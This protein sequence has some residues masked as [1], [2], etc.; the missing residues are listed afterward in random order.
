MLSFLTAVFATLSSVF[1]SRSAFQLEN[2]ALR[3]QIGVL[4]RVGRKR[5]KLMPRDRLLWVWLSRIWSGWRSALAIVRP[6]TFIAC[7]RKGFRLFWV[8]KI[9]QGQPGRPTLPRDVRDLIRRMCRENPTWLRPGEAVGND[10]LKGGSIRPSVP[11]DVAYEVGAA[12]QQT[13]RSPRTMYPHLQRWHPNR[14][15]TV[16]PP[17]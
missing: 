2:L 9:R 10:F 1:R 15:A 17:A 16:Y 7:H 5:P 11:S 14:E 4:Q 6:E 12:R 13:V 3:H 8:W